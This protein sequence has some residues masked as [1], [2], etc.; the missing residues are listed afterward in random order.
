MP[1]ITQQVFRT[2]LKSIY[3]SDGGSGIDI[4][5]VIIDPHPQ[6]PHT[7]ASMCLSSFSG[8]TQILLD[9]TFIMKYRSELI[10]Q[11][12]QRGMVQGAR[13]KQW[14]FFSGNGN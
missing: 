6:H 7:H 2:G 10:D 5:V 9:C 11:G 14:C 13:K 1:E 8:E 4:D 12:N 3:D